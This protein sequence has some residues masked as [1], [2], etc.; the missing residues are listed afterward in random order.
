V[1]VTVR[2]DAKVR[3]AIAAIDGK[4]WTTIEYPNA[5]FD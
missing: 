4:A 2:L 1:S 3:A 5:V